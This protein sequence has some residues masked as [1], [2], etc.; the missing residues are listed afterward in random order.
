MTDVVVAVGQLFTAIS[1]LVEFIQT[2]SFFVAKGN[3]GVSG[4]IENFRLPVF[5][6]FRP[7]DP[8]YRTGRAVGR[9]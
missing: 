6:V 5:H 4:R 8:E 1:Q 9:R 3:S 7:A 2:E